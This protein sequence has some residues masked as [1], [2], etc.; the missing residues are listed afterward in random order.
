M[1]CTVSTNLSSA[2]LNM[3]SNS[4]QSRVAIED[5][6][7]VELITATLH[8]ISARG[9]ER[10][11][12][13]D[14]ASAAGASVGSVNYYFKSKDELLRAAV[15]ETDARF[16]SQVRDAVEDAPEY[17]AKLARVVDLCFP[18]EAADGPDWA[19]FVDFWYRASR[20][21]SYRA[22]FEEAH[23]EWIALLSQVLADGAADGVFFLSADPGDEALAFASMI[24]GLALYTRVTKHV[25]VDTARRIA[26]EHVDA[27]CQKAAPRRRVKQRSEL[28][29]GR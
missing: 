14:I 19:V 25:D 5:I 13:R 1:P 17:P 26:K 20:Q 3:E 28:G 27:L 9:F 11:T 6:R 23:S 16:R 15:A 8:V 7:R 29:V 22:I 2:R 18:D 12:V 4:T 21:S 24:D 10:T